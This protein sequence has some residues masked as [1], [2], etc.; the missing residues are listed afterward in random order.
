[1]LLS[2]L[3]TDISRQKSLRHHLII[4]IYFTETIFKFTN[5]LFTSDIKNMDTT[6]HGICMFF[7]YKK[8]N[9][10]KGS[11]SDTHTTREFCL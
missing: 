5:N 8:L 11:G 6:L 1:M 9:Q 7:L 4:L 10:A 2:S 3:H